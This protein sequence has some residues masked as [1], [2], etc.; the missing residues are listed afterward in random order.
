MV[1]LRLVLPFF[2][3]HNKF[4][5]KTQITFFPRNPIKFVSIQFIKLIWIH[6]SFSLRWALNSR[7]ESDVIDFRSNFTDGKFGGAERTCARRRVSPGSLV[8]ELARG[9]E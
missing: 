4:L 5:D 3:H 1:A 6:F 8:D 2:Y 7:S 9:D